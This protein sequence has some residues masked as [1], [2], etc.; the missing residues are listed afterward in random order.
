MKKNSIFAV[1]LGAYFLFSVQNTIAVCSAASQEDTWLHTDTWLQ[2]SRASGAGGIGV[3]ENPEGTTTV[4][5][6]VG[7][8]PVIGLLLVS[9]FYCVLLRKNKINYSSDSNVP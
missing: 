8:L 5:A 9:T 7:Q 6:P 1:V 2:E 3:G 4:G